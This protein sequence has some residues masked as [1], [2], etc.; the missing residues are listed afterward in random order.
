MVCKEAASLRDTNLID[1]S[2]CKAADNVANEEE[3]GDPG[4]KE[5]VDLDRVVDRRPVHHL[6]NCHAGE[7]EPTTNNGGSIFLVY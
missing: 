5:E 7:G 3:A 4:A 2:S 6:G 1:D